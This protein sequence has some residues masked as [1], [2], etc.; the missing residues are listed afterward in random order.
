MDC[1][2]SVQDKTDQRGDSYS[3]TPVADSS[4]DTEGKSSTDENQSK[5]INSS[6]GAGSRVRAHLH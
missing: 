1:P 3:A 5:A 4:N 6:E 2:E